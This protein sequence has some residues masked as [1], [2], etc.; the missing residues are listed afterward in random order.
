M[1]PT[2]NLLRG[3]GC[4]PRGFHPR[5]FQLIRDKLAG[6]AWRFAPDDQSIN[7]RCDRSP[8]SFKRCTCRPARLFRAVEK[9]GG[10][11]AHQHVSYC[12]SQGA[13]G[14]RKGGRSDVEIIIKKM[15]RLDQTLQSHG[16]IVL[17]LLR[18]KLCSPQLRNQSS[19]PTTGW[20]PG[21]NRP[22]ALE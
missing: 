19:V 3:D 12:G 13:K 11:G 6:S 17:L 4:P 2:K 18:C 14:A 9:Q 1:S 15:Q 7:R 21:S 22:L 8:D 10:S 16:Q 5:V 20:T